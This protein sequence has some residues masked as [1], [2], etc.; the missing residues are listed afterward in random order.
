M[1]ILIKMT[2]VKTSYYLSSK[3]LFISHVREAVGTLILYFQLITSCRYMFFI[4]FFLIL[5]ILQ[6]EHDS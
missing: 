4:D 2:L 3:V 6:Y 5:V 1:S